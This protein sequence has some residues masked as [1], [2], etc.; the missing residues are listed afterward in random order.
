MLNPDV[1][2]YTK[3]LNELKILRKMQKKHQHTENKR[4]RKP[5]YKLFWIPVLT[6]S[7]SGGKFTPLNPVSSTTA[8]NTLNID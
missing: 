2:G 5:K 4:I 7:L 3:T 8:T 1:D 6:F